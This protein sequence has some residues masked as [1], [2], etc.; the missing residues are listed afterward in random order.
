[1]EALPFLKAVT[2]EAAPGN[3]SGSFIHWWLPQFL[4]GIDG[5]GGTLALAICTSFS[6]IVGVSRS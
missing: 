6:A 5:D 4:R 1:M 3:R 2:L